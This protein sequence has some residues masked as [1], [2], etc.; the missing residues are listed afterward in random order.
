MPREA[1]PASQ[2]TIAVQKDWAEREFLT[3]VQLGVAQLSAFL[4]D[5]GARARTEKIIYDGIVCSRACFYSDRA[6]VLFRVCALA[7]AATRGRLSALDG[8]LSRLERRMQVVEATL[9]SVDKS[10][11]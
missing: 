10:S 4:N 2:N 11:E 8:K 3:S 5:F 1:D 9:E 7:D 6:R